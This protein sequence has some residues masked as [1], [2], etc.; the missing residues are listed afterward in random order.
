MDDLFHKLAD[1]WRDRVYS[2]AL[3]SLRRQEE[4][5]DVTQRVLIRLWQN[6]DAIDPDR[7]GAWIMRVT[8]NAVIDS[9]RRRSTRSSVIAEGADAKDAQMY[10]P[11]GARTES[12]VEARE[13]REAVL[14]ALE[15]IDEVYRSVIIMREI[16]QFTYSEIAN[17]LQ[18]P[19]GTVKVHLHR[20][21]RALRAA[22]RERYREDVV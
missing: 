18:L 14:A 19:V 7:A 6:C 13:I 8:R 5:E 11:S 1:Q 3:Y 4:A 17:A 15:E 10:V 9:T 20:G 21:R 12:T 16:E 2:F 22:I